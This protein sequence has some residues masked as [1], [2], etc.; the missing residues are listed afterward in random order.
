MVRRRQSEHLGHGADRHRNAERGGEPPARCTAPRW[1]AR[2]IAAHALS[3][4]GDHHDVMAV[5]QP[6]FGLLASNSVQEMM[7][8]ALIAQAASMEARVR[9]YISSTGF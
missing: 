4:F 9:S 6:G 5:R 7:D 1:S 3:I 8:F 2:S